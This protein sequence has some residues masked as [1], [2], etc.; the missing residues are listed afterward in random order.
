MS[1]TKINSEQIKDL[2]A[3]LELVKFLEENIGKNLLDIGLG[4][5]FFFGYD[6]KAQ[7][8]TIKTKLNSIKVKTYAQEYRQSTE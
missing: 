3:S 6:I 5:G 8:T 1:H 2:S 4:N 7:S